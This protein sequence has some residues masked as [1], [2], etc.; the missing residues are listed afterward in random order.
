MNDAIKFEQMIGKQILAL[1]PILSGEIVQEITIRGVEAGGLWIESETISKAWLQKLDL[2]VMRAPIFFV[3]YHEIRFLFFGGEKLEL[4]E[5][6][7]G[8]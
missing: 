4:S 2:P 7:F 3:P 6:K 5:K 8:V 1:I